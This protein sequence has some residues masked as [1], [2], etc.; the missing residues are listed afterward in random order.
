MTQKELTSIFQSIHKKYFPRKL[1]KIDAKFFSFRRI[2]HSIEWT[3]FHIRIKVS[4]YFKD[5]PHSIM[6]ILAIILIAR[7]YKRRVDSSIRK[8]YREYLEQLEQKLPPTRSHSLDS[9]NAKGK[10]FDLE[11]VFLQLNMNY[12]ENLLDLPVLGWSK[13]KSY[14]RLGF[15]DEKRNLL[16]ISRIFDASSVPEEIVN[17]LVYHEMLHIYYPAEKKNGRRIVHTPA[18]KMAEKR[19]PKYENIQTWLKK[20]LSKL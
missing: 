11:S 5:A 12:F 10:V 8:K 19:F 20:N 18:F 17:Y 15:Y 3:P 2:K 9:Y 1:K 6:E 14:R 13:T 7:I 16:V 4:H